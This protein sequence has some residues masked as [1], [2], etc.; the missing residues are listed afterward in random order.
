MA[1]T[2]TLLNVSKRINSTAR[3]STSGGLS[4][5]CNLKTA[6]TI[7]NPD[8]EFQFAMTFNPNNYN[9]VYVGHW[10]KYYFIEDWEYIDRLWIAHCALDTL[11]TYRSEIFNDQA[12]ILYSASNGNKY[13]VDSRIPPEAKT[14]Y[15][16][17]VS[18]N[19]LPN[20]N[21][22]YIV[23]VV[24][25]G[26]GLTGF[27]LSESSFS[28]LGAVLSSDASFKEQVTQQYGDAFGCFA[29]CMHFPFA[30]NFGAASTV[31]LG[32][33]NTGVGG[34]LVG[35]W[36]MNYSTSLS[37]GRY[38]DDWRDLTNIT[39]L[40]WL[41]YYGC[42]ELSASELLDAGSITVEVAIEFIGGGMVYAVHMGTDVQTFSTSCGNSVP[43]TG[44]QSNYQQAIHSS[45]QGGASAL[46]AIG[47]ASG[48]GGGGALSAIFGGIGDVAGGIE[49][50]F[51]KS[52][53]IVGGA[54]G[55]AWE[56]LES[57]AVTLIRIVSPTEYNPSDVASVIGRPMMKR[58]TI[59]NL[60][61]FT[62]TSNFA[63]SGTMDK[64]EKQE[65]NEMMNGGVY[66][67]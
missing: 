45:V 36:V 10:K 54:T 30:P 37:V 33:Y 38:Y 64:A 5:G 6:C 13:L 34:Y 1:F 7:H 49:S 65:I 41:P 2:V 26:G 66:I 62:V 47:A 58:A 46:S 39:Y 43:I 31:S 15:L 20:S 14:Q 32:A 21:P 28:S 23:R 42:V 60:S 57:R 11:A 25:A 55:Q 18:S 51:T 29:S 24:G 22:I 3:P 67:E 40:L 12:F 63:V 35:R 16:S 4:M 44:Y 53:R 48:G 52:A 59:G 9:Y 17:N 19:L 50:A 8:F 27:I 61:G 56:G